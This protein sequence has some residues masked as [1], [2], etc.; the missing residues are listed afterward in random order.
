VREVGVPMTDDERAA[1]RR[2][3]G[4]LANLTLGEMRAYRDGH[5]TPLRG[6]SSR[7][8]R[9]LCDRLVA[10]QGKRQAELTDADYELMA[11]AISR[12]HLLLR[13]RPDGAIRCSA[14]RRRLLLLG[15]DPLRDDPSAAE[16]WR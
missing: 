11:R 13:Q 5:G 16:G 10:I 12:I 4:D 6:S 3:Y 8:E 2:V 14:W 9:E 1:I 15:H 7:S